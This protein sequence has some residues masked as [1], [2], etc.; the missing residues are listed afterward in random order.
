MKKTNTCHVCWAFLLSTL[1]C[2]CSFGDRQTHS[3]EIVTENGIRIS[4]TQGGPKYSG[5]IFDYEYVRTL[6]EDLQNPESLLDQPAW[7]AMDQNGWC[8]L[9]HNHDKR[10][11]VFNSNGDYVS[12][13]GRQGEGP[14]EFRNPVLQYISGDTLCI[15]DPPLQR[16]TLYRTDGTLLGVV[17]TP[18][19]VGY[20][21][22]MFVNRT[23]EVIGLGDTGHTEGSA[24]L[25]RMAMFI[26]SPA[27]DT[28]ASQQTILVETGY[29]IDA[30]GPIRQGMNYFYAP[31]ATAVVD[32]ARG[33]VWLNSGDEPLI[34]GYSMDGDLLED[35]ILGDQLEPLTRSILRAEFREWAKTSDLPQ[36]DIASRRNALPDIQI[37]THKAYSIRTI[38]DHGF[39]WLVKPLSPFA[40]PSQPVCRIVSPDGEYLGDTTW[41]VFVH[42]NY[43]NV[44][45]GHFLCKDV[46]EETGAESA[47]VYRVHSRVDGLQYPG[48]D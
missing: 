44:I 42:W 17:R 7:F 39:T 48:M 29:V 9:L 15:F 22:G 36:E 34:R 3:F 19:N 35:V 1:I 11:Q 12:S 13:F 31:A 43:A 5:E 30:S 21:H 33:R 6:S 8:Y 26:F 14:G 41:P 46:D 24:T 2:S 40:Q 20:L 4:R 18:P 32:V 10:I 47:V 16:T 38:V 37:R 28:L 25:D 45:Q 23:G 27:G